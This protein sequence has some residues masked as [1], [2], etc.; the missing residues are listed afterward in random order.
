VVTLLELF[1]S[2][3][4]P[5]NAIMGKAAPERRLQMLFYRDIN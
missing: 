5:A 3:P 2:D 4:F 1:S